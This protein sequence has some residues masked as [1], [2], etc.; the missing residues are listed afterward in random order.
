[1]RVGRTK[2]FAARFSAL[3][4]TPLSRHARCGK[5]GMRSGF[6]QRQ[7]ISDDL[8]E[9]WQ[10]DG[11]WRRWMNEREGS[12]CAWCKCSLRSSVLGSAIARVIG[13]FTHSQ[14][15]SL[16]QAFLHPCSRSLGIAEINKAGDLHDVL[17]RSASL[18]YSEFG[19]TD[20][21]VP[22]EDLRRLSYASECL[23][24]VITSDTLEHVPD[25]DLALSEI[26]RALKRG[27]A[28]VFTVPIVAGRATRRRAML[29]GGDLVHLLPPSFHGRSGTAAD[30]LLVFH[31][32]GF[33]FVSR[34]VDAGFEV[35]QVDGPNPAAF[36]LIAYKPVV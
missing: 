15:S 7:F 29:R 5:C 35:V 17:Q 24:L 1:M 13:E 14:P 12:R 25:V 18:R 8:F 6:V 33:D 11:D 9:Q 27:G 20:P 23:D 3:L 22:S 30:D 31:E 4:S 2:Y 21:R 10:L 32:F 26:H 19:S 28:H 36:A 16:K 34:C